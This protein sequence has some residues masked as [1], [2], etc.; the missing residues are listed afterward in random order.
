M[1]K[2]KSAWK[3][4]E[5]DISLD[6][7]H[8]HCIQS[9]N[10]HIFVRRYTSIMCILIISFR[11]CSFWQPLL[12][13]V[14]PLPKVAKLRKCSSCQNSVWHD[15]S[16]VDSDKKLSTPPEMLNF[17][18]PDILKICIDMIIQIILPG[19]PIVGYLASGYFSGFIV[20]HFFL[21]RYPGIRISPK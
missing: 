3:E 1:H 10:Q 14:T 7:W 19:Y 11:V 5:N 18:S 20:A 8:K 15:T 9:K 4:Y 6:L 16:G 21:T 12:F 13:R 17:L 2:T